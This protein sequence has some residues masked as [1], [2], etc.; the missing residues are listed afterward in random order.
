MT[1][2][3]TTP[4]RPA[5]IDPLEQ[6]IA[7]KVVLPRLREL[8]SINQRMPT[9]K[10][11]LYSWWVQPWPGLSRARFDSWIEMLGIRFVR[12][13]TVQGLFEEERTQAVPSSAAEDE[14]ADDRFDNE[15]EEDFS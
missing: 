4:V 3:R 13:V 7:R 6:E 10:S 12:T 5:S 1:Q 9:S 14:Q 11:E 8:V 2:A 15:S